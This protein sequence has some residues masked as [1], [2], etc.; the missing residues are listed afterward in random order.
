MTKKE[1]VPRNAMI[2]QMILTRKGGK[3]RDRKRE[4]REKWDQKDD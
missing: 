4:S 2:L 3:H 1:A